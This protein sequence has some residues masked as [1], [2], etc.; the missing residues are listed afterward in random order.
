[1]EMEMNREKIITDMENWLSDHDVNY[2]HLGV[3][4]IYNEW[5]KNKAPLIEKLRQHPN[6]D[7][8]NL[9]IVL[10]ESEYERAFNKSA[11]YDFKYWVMNEIDEELRKNSVRRTRKELAN[12]KELLEYLR[13]DLRSSNAKGLNL[14]TPE[15]EPARYFVEREYEET[16][17]KLN[18]IEINYKLYRDEWVKE[19]IKNKYRRVIDALD[20]CSSCSESNMLTEQL[21]EQ[22]NKL[23]P[24]I[25]AVQGQKLSRVIQKI[26]KTVDIDKIVKINDYGTYTRDDGFNRQFAIL[27]N[28]INPV[29][30]KRIT[31]ISLN[32][33]DYWSMSH[34][35]N[36]HS[37][38]YVGDGDDGCYSSGTESYML[39]GTSIV[40]YIID[41]KYTGNTYSLEDKINRCMFMV[42]PDGNAILESRVYPDDRDGGDNSLARQFRDVMSRIVSELW[43]VNNFW[44]IKKGSEAGY[45]TTT[46]GT[47]Y[48]D[49]IKYEDANTMINKSYT[50]EVNIVI[51]H[52]PICPVCGKEHSYEENVICEDCEHEGEIRCENCGEYE[53]EEDAIHTSDDRW[54]CCEDCAN[55]AGYYYCEDTGEYENENNMQKI[56]GRWYLTENCYYNNYTGEYCHGEPEV[57]TEDDR[58]YETEDEAIQDGYRECYEDNCWYSEEDM[59]ADSEGDWHLKENAD[60]QTEDGNYFWNEEEAKEAGYEYDEEAEEWRKSA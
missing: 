29:T 54:F 55:G 27:A 33:V 31:V 59:F 52:D 28:E 35:K 39:D 34:G 18:N 46:Y 22:I 21:A 6:W 14:M 57:T 32:P 36:W 30:Y 48:P 53:D 50:G 26:C 24:E 56:D 40:Y 25:K 43:E 9:A 45:L 11:L 1:M 10:K 12:K 3:K 2:T 41:E 8:D 20:I 5:L 4:A 37:C 38:H 42:Q 44:E 17:E 23:I 19:E 58:N 15:G 47:H 51:G 49:Y 7:E 16:R 60:V 13:S